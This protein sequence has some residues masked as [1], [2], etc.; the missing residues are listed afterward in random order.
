MSHFPSSTIM[1][2]RHT[3]TDIKEWALWSMMATRAMDTIGREPWPRTFYLMLSTH[4]A[5]LLVETSRRKATSSSL[6]AW[7]NS[8]YS[9]LCKNS[10]RFLQCSVLRYCVKLSRHPCYLLRPTTCPPSIMRLSRILDI[11]VNPH[12]VGIYLAIQLFSSWS[13]RHWLYNSRILNILFARLVIQVTIRVDVVPKV[14]KRVLDYKSFRSEVS[15]PAISSY[16]LRTPRNRYSGTFDK[17]RGLILFSVNICRMNLILKSSPMSY[18]HRRVGTPN[19][20]ILNQTCSLDED[21]FS[22][23]I[24]GPMEIDNP[25]E[26]QFSTLTS[27]TSWYSLHPKLFSLSTKLLE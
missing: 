18:G 16:T 4:R 6:Q 10:T 11:L 3:S 5:I 12:P 1:I 26:C 9:L 24:Q 13:S 21:S 2:C 22:F 14:L 19:E 25:F 15:M 27:P 23:A 7:S 8:A 20:Q 17:V